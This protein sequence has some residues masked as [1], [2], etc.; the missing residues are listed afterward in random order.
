MPEFAT[1]FDGATVKIMA[2]AQG[3]FAGED[4]FVSAGLGL[5]YFPAPWLSASAY[6]PYKWKSGIDTQTDRT[7][8]LHGFGDISAAATLDLLELITPTMVVTRCPE[9]GGPIVMM[10]DEDRVVKAP[11]LGI[12]IGMSFPVGADGH[13]DHWWVIPARY[14]PGAGVWMGSVGLNYSQGFGPVA[15]GLFAAYAGSLGSNSTGLERPDLLSFGGS[16]NWLF[17]YKRRARLYTGVNTIVPLGN[18]R[19]DGKEVPGTAATLVTLDVGASI[20]AL[21]LGNRKL[22]LGLMASF[23]L[24]EGS[25]ASGAA[26][27][28]GLSG[29]FAVGI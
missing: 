12:S 6:V 1:G 26:V 10:K 27:G 9:T 24:K 14:Q 2:G 29:F 19:Q 3:R 4:R 22:I 20:W 28:T 7:V 11:H 25:A 18:V 5:K 21:S 8:D 16:L 17:W 23:P 15:L 13:K